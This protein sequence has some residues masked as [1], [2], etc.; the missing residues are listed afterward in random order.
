MSRDV[1]YF[2]LKITSNQRRLVLHSLFWVAWLSRTLYDII[3]I[4]GI[5]SAFLFSFTYIFTQMP[6]VYLHLYI[7]VPKYLNTKKY[8]QYLI[9][10]ISSLFVYSY[11]NYFVLHQLPLSWITLK[12][13]YYINTLAPLYDVLE[14]LFAFVI[15]YALKYTWLAISTQ[16]KILELEKDN[17]QL[18]LNV[19][20]AQVNPHFLFNSLNNIYALSLQKSEKTPEIVLKLS[21]LMRYV[22]YD[23][24]APKVKVVKEIQFI[25][26]YIE[27]EKIR[28]HNNEKITFNLSGMPD[29]SEIEPFLLI[30]FVENA[31]KHGLNNIPEKNWINIDLEFSNGIIKLSV[32]NS[33]DNNNEKK[34]LANGIGLQNVKKRL[35]LL[36][37]NSHQ[38]KISL[39]ETSYKTELSININ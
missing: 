36:Y 35:L 20:K 23:C 15:T 2:N 3:R 9:L 27:L 12:M 32:E 24:N 17:L 25:Y 18:E 19:L 16:N 13:S 37:P 30:P 14:G 29:E 7:L 1:E 39:N 22:L 28:H 8:A 26:D 11:F 6:F 5:E 10:T 21:N 38:L 31:F 34:Q 33:K 4:F